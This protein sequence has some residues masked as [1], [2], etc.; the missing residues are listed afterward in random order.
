MSRLAKKPIAIGKTDVSVAG[1]MLSVKGT[2]GTLTKRLH[3]SIEIMV[4]STGV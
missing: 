4:D 1:S 2:K 3:P